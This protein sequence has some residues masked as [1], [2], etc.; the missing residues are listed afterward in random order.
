VREAL[1]QL[2]GLR[3]VETARYR[4]SRVREISDREMREASEV[5]GILEGFAVDRAIT[6]SKQV[7]ETLQT[8]MARMSEAAEAGNV[9]VFAHHDTTFHQV[10]VDA[11]DHQVLRRTWESLGVEV[12]IR[13][14]L[15]RGD[16]DL[17]AV[18][19]LH[20]PIVKALTAGNGELAGDLRRRHAAMVEALRRNGGPARDP[21]HPG[22]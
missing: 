5:R 7:L 14:L 12:R 8:A 15:A 1:R 22:G 11:A 20:V 13:L 10:I 19:K 16:Y 9:E 3:L 21:S 18:L 2:E 4:G 6:P 17:R